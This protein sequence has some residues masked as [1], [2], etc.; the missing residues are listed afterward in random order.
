MK[1]NPHQ[2]LVR[3]WGFGKKTANERDEQATKTIGER[4]RN[5]D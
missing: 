5:A 2:G 4:K 3:G 1:A